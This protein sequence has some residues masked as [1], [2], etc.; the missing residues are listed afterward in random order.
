MSDIH[1]EISLFKRGIHTLS[2]RVSIHGKKLL[3]PSYT[4]T[5]SS[6]LEFELVLSHV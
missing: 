2:Y 4:N 3:L 5:D 1:Y 6:S